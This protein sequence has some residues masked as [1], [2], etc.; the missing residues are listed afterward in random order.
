M[1]DVLGHRSRRDRFRSVDR[2]ENTREIRP[3]PTNGPQKVHSLVLRQLVFADDTI[4]AII[5]NTI[6][7]LILGLQNR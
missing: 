6:D 4:N 5:V 1:G 3:D 7:D 2:C